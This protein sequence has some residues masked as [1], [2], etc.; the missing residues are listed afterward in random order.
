MSKYIIVKLVINHPNNQSRL[1]KNY[2][3]KSWSQ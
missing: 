2:N 1:N 3:K